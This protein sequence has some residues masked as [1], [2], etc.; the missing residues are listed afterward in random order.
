MV[1][2]EEATDSTPGED[3]VDFSVLPPAHSLPLAEI[4]NTRSLPGFLR[5][6]GI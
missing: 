5:H 2:Y 1:E 6:S 3:P 4:G